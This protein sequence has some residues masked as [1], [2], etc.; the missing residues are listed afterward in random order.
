M[1]STLKMTKPLKQYWCTAGTRFFALESFFTDEGE[2]Y[3]DQDKYQIKC[4]K[5]KEITSPDDRMVKFRDYEFLIK[6]YARAE[7]C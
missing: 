5:I 7:D 6:V 4:E 3:R 2:E 1:K